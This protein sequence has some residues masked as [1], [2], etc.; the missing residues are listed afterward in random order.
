MKAQPDQET[1]IK[2]YVLDLDKIERRILESGGRL[3]QSR[4][5][6]SNLRFD[7]PDG[8]LRR[9]GRVLRL[10]QDRASY[11]TYKGPST[12]TDGVVSRA[13]YEFTVSDFEMA[14]RT[15]EALGY[16]L[17]AV[18]EKYRGIYALDDSLI[19]LDKLPY[20]HFVEIEGRD[21][22][23]I[24]KITEKLEINFDCA[25]PN[26]YL[27]LF[28]QFCG[29]FNLDPKKLTFA[30]LANISITAQDLGVKP[31]DR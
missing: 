26:S 14:R 16:Q 18:Y 4:I 13:E 29:Q 28:E 7:L 20:G 25:V 15:I 10:R 21:I 22:D 1:E 31:A 17:T 23:A 2:L 11:L 30:A 8:S 27:S 3:I 19:M 6:E 12:R 5:F 24:R 9:D